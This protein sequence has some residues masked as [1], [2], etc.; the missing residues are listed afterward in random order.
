MQIRQE[1]ITLSAEFGQI[2]PLY[3]LKKQISKITA[4][5]LDLEADEI[6]FKRSLGQY[7]FDSM[8]LMPYFKRLQAEVSEKLTLTI[9][10]E[11]HTIEQIAS[12]LT[13][14]QPELITQGKIEDGL[15]YGEIWRPAASEVREAGDS[16]I[17][18]LGTV[19]AHKVDDQE[20][21]GAANARSS[22][23]TKRD[24]HLNTLK[25]MFAEILE[26]NAEDI[27]INR[28]LMNYGYGENDASALRKKIFDRERIDISDITL[29]GCY[30]LRDVANVML[31]SQTVFHVYDSLSETVVSH[32]TEVDLHTVE[33]KVPFQPKN[34]LKIG[35]KTGVSERFPELVKLNNIEAGSPVIWIHNEYGYVEIY[36]EIASRIN[37]PFYAIRPRS[38]GGERQPFNSIT[39]LATYYAHIVDEMLPQDV[40]ELGGHGYGAMIA[41][42]L[43]RQLKEVGKTVTTLVSVD[44][45]TEI[46]RL[47]DENNSTNKIIIFNRIV[48]DAFGAQTLPV[49]G[50]KL[51]E[52]MVVEEEDLDE[53]LLKLAS[54]LLG[55]DPAAEKQHFASVIDTVNGVRNA[56]SDESL[57]FNFL[58]L[59]AANET[60][61]VNVVCNVSQVTIDILKDYFPAKRQK[62]EIL[63]ENRSDLRLLSMFTKHRTIELDVDTSSAMADTTLIHVICDQYVD[64][65]MQT[66]PTE[67]INVHSRYPELVKLNESEEGVPVIWLHAGLGGVE[68]YQELASKSERPFYAIQARGWLTNRLPLDGLQAMAAYYVQII[69]SLLPGPFDLGGYSFGGNIAYEVAR[70]L[71]EL[72]GKV[73]SVIMLDSHDSD[74]LRRFK[75]SDKS[76]VLQ[77]VNVFLAGAMMAEDPKG[78]FRALISRDQIDPTL[79]ED[80]IFTRVINIAK[81][82][83]LK[84]TERQIREATDKN[85]SIQ[86]GYHLNNFPFRPMLLPEETN[87]YY[88]R[89]RDGVFYGMLEPFFSIEP[90]PSEFVDK[91]NYWAQWTDNLPNFTIFDLD[92]E[93]HM[94]LLSDPSIS[95][96]IFEFCSELYSQRGIN[97]EFSERFAKSLYLDH[98]RN[99]IFALKRKLRKVTMKLIFKIALLFRKK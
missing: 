86:K 16:I 41:Y 81:C 48:K 75:E 88:F 67:Q 32:A 29:L 46:G 31:Q 96:S 90:N 55:D 92:A 83:G 10:R 30:N 66:L 7:G 95:K 52:E 94:V 77:T 49:I 33:G 42:E 71:K 59:V 1:S 8:L 57:T 20:M 23:V 51:G 74:A 64:G 65:S 38:W 5:L 24:Q 28:P 18:P 13:K 68:A 98:G 72:G 53:G 97:E 93:S 99:G 3:T 11:S 61:L 47:C 9:L 70:Q 85:L 79:P 62:N 43:A 2:D 27:N 35:L 60:R 91:T 19:V 87:F 54:T 34:R 56:L 40:Y 69:S 25:T 73:N 6:D 15:L 12:R 58:P 36:Q 63:F 22:K 4:E 17:P 45:P 80:E 21:M 82:R 89:N 44:A 39:A 14:I 26:I 78:M 84:K 50:I 37:R 76:P